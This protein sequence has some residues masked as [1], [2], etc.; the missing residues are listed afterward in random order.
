MLV[1]HN[2]ISNPNHDDYG[3]QSSSNFVEEFCLLTLPIHWLVDNYFLTF[4]E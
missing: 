3:Q 1:N 2:T 4:Y